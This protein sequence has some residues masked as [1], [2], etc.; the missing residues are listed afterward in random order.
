MADGQL[1]LPLVSDGLAG[2]GCGLGSEL[3]EMLDG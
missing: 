3:P 2:S 1:L